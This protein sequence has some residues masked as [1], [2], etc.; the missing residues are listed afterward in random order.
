MIYIYNRQINYSYRMKQAISTKMLENINIKNQTLIH[1]KIF[2]A[3]EI[4]RR[5]MKLVCMR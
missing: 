3:V 1:E 5:T 4:H 2:Y